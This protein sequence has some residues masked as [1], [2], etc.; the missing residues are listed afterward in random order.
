MRNQACA[1]H[2][3]RLSYR[4]GKYFLKSLN[5]TER[6]VS[7]FTNL[8]TSKML[9]KLENLC[10]ILIA[11]KYSAEE[12]STNFLS[13]LLIFKSDKIFFSSGFF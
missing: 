7:F 3:D 11:C 10:I 12:I 5:N 13:F 8:Q 1:D 6:L 9:H 2:K 4:Q